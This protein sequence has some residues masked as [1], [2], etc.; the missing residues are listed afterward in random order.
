M[1]KKTQNFKVKGQEIHGPD[2]FYYK[3]EE[4]PMMLSA[5]FE[6]AWSQGN[7]KGYAEAIADFRKLKP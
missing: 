2:K 1:S 5:L 4:D 6:L 7:R 3:T